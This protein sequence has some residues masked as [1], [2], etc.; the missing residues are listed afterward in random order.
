MRPEVKLTFEIYIKLLDRYVLYIKHGDDIRTDRLENLKKRKVRQLFIPAEHESDYQIF[1]DNYL[2]EAGQNVMMST[3]EKAEVVNSYATGATEEIFKDPRS[4][5]SYV[6]AQKAAKG[7]LDIVVKNEDVLKSLVMS[8]LTSDSDNKSEMLIRNSVNVS[9]IAVKFGEKM[10]LSNADQEILG[11]AGLFHDIGISKL[12]PRA[13]DLLFIKESE[14]V[15]S[16]WGIYKSH[17]ETGVDLLKDRDYVS[18]DLLLLILQHE[19]KKSGSGFPKGLH[20]LSKQQEIFNLCCFYSKQVLYLKIPPA[21]VLKSIM[22]DEVGN[23]ELSLL[24]KFR[25]FLKQ[26]GLF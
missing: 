14:Y 26:E 24:Q 18:P 15:A 6:K 22:I 23:Y 4:K 12:P 25:D 9:T 16:D 20:K 21:E 1:L 13:L 17:P 19:E 5:K 7:I 11:M 8:N 3:I 2:I 10:G